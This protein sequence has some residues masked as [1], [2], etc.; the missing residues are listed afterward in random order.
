MPNAPS[1]RRRST[2]FHRINVPVNGQQVFNFFNA[3]RAGGV[4]NLEQAGTLPANTVAT[5]THVR[6]S[7]LPGFDVAGNR[8]GIAAP[9]QAQ[10]QASLLGSAGYGTTAA[11]PIA[12][13]PIALWFEKFRELMSQGQA[14]FRI[15]E[16]EIFSAYGLT[17]FPEGRGVVPQ[18][19]TSAALANSTASTVNT[20]HETF[21]GVFNGAPVIGNAWKLD[22]DVKIF[23]G[24]QFALDV[25]YIKPVNFAEQYAGPLYNIAGAV[26]A[27][28]LMAELDILLDTLA[29]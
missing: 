2:I 11:D 22:G 3:S 20:F 21:A 18:V 12:A 15:G 5:V 4:T 8:L 27:G 10:I 9:T 26:T 7:F 28:V 6:F 24:K 16:R 19:Q 23:S 14:S 17:K 25:N 13:S 1:F 29:Q